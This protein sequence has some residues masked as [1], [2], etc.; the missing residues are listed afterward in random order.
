LPKINFNLVDVLFSNSPFGANI[1]LDGVH[2]SAQGQSIL[3][4]AA[5][6]AINARY[7]VTI[8]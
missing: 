8:P 1:S 7:G 6:Q 5:V 2:P 4:A 3:A